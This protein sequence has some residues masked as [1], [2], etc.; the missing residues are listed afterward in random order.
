MALGKQDLKDDQQVQ[1]DTTKID[2]IHQYS[3]YY[4]LDR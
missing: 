4:E 2:F 1:V 3:S